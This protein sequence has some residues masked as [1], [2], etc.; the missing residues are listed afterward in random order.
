MG[1]TP[2]EDKTLLYDFIKNAICADPKDTITIYC[3]AVLLEDK[4]ILKDIKQEMT[5]KELEDLKKLPI[6]F[7]NKG[8]NDG[9]D[10]N[11]E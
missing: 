1:C 5:S 2:L 11:A 9:K 10:E 8:E 6:E 7:V 3:S 4:E